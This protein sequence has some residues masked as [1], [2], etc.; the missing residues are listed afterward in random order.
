MLSLAYQPT[1]VKS[2][3]P[4]AVTTASTTS[5]TLAIPAPQPVDQPRRRSRRERARLLSALAAGQLP[6]TNLRKHLLAA[7]LPDDDGGDS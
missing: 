2:R 6:P 3:F 7:E 4:A 1:L 5:S